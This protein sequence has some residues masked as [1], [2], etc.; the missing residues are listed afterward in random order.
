MALGGRIY[1][2]VLVKSVGQPVAGH[3]DSGQPRTPILIQEDGPRRH[4]PVNPSVRVPLLNDEEE[5][6]RPPVTFKSVECNG[7]FV[8]A[9]GPGDGIGHPPQLAAFEAHPFG[10]QPRDAQARGHGQQGAPHHVGQHAPLFGSKSLGRG[11]S[12]APR[13]L[14]G[15]RGR[16]HGHP[17]RVHRV[18]PFEF[19]PQVAAIG[20]GGHRGQKGRRLTHRRS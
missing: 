12:E 4:I 7:R 5:A 1:R 16:L 3:P 15:P 20:H 6:L 8:E 13:P 17:Y 2:I 19:P 14:F 18:R 11:L 10:P 9:H